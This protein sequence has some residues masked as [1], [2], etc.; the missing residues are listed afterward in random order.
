MQT[1]EEQLEF[2]NVGSAGAIGGGHGPA[3]GQYSHIDDRNAGATGGFIRQ[4]RHPVAALFHFLFKALAILIYLFGGWI[5]TNFIF[6]FVCCVLLLAFDF[7]TVKNVTGRLLVGLRWW[8][9][10]KEDGSTEWV[11]ESLED[12]DEVH[13]TDSRLFWM[14][15]YGTPVI[16]GFFL[17][18]G[19]LKLNIQ[20]L[21]IVVVALSL[22]GANIV[23]YTKCRKDAKQK[24]ASFVEG[25]VSSMMGNATFRNSLL[26]FVTGGGW[27]SSSSNKPAARQGAYV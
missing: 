8:S 6:L 7:W 26:S 24:L 10:V 11:F 18:I 14:G 15:L 22:S 25:G 20:W 5:S 2:I 27:D 3:G 1:N 12:L 4:S 21:I 17:F 19:I 13:A 9:N 23:G 16:W